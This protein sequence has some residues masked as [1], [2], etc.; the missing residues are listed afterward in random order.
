VLTSLALGAAFLWLPRRYAPVLPVAVAAGFLLTWLPLELWTHSFP[1]LASSSYA[2]GVSPGHRSW[3]DRIAGRNARVGVVWAGGNELSVW[4]NEFWNRSV[5]RVYDLGA[6]IPGDMPSIPLAVD[7]ATGVLRGA[8]GQTIRERYVLAPTSVDLLGK[9]VARDAPKNLVLYRVSPPAR[10]TT[11]VTGLYPEPVNPWSNASPVWTRYRCPG[12][13]LTV[14]FS[15][16]AQ[17]FRG[18]TQTV[19]VTG[20]TPARSF[21]VPSKASSVTER[22]PLTPQNGVCRVSFAI[23]PARRPSQYPALHRND[24]RLLGLHFDSIAYRAPR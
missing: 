6:R 4:E 11:T 15:S 3:I 8:K 20:T 1:R 16:D 18:V 2:Q 12:G 7:Q 13:T 19:R 23:S 14:V 5:D 17:L 10:I 24:S 21:R 22:F 9:P